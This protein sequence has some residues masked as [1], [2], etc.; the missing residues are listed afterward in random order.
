VPKT[1]TTFYRIFPGH[2][3]Q[4]SDTPVNPEW[5]H[6]HGPQ[7]NVSLSNMVPSCPGERLGAMAADMTSAAGRRNDAFPNAGSSNAVAREL[8]TPAQP[9]VDNLERD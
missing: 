4:L 8:Q 9:P 5:A 2:S 7:R 1:L 3:P 6:R